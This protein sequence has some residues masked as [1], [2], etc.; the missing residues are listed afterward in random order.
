MIRVCYSEFELKI[1]Q[2][3]LIW[4]YVLLCQL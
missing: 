1:D 3:I 2:D 4:F